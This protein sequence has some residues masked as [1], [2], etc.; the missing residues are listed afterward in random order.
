MVPI[1]ITAWLL[2]SNFS[3][4]AGYPLDATL[5]YLYR[6]GNWVL[7][8]ARSEAMLE[9]QTV[10]TTMV[11]QERM[12][13]SYD[14]I[15]SG[16]H[17]WRYKTT[18]IYWELKGAEAK[19]PWASIVWT[20]GGIP[21]YSFLV[22]LV[23]LNRC[24]TRDRLLAWGLPVDSSCLLCNLEFESRDHLFFRCPYSWRVWSEISRRCLISPLQSWQDTVSQLLALT[25]NK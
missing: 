24:L 9:V 25:R 22:W 15:V 6:S 4:R 20:K 8:R 23:L 18:Q 3:L 12:E 11:L 5:S 10:L 21:K 1:W 17:T 16:V 2:C 13:D 14:W 19:V 7:P